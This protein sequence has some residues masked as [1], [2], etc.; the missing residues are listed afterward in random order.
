LHKYLPIQ[1][2]QPGNSDVF[3]NEDI[4][5]NFETAAASIGVN[6]NLHF[7]KFRN[8]V[9]ESERYFENHYKWKVLIG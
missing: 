1:S 9:R 3:Q 5:I 4:L 6:R 8:R 2:W 7:E